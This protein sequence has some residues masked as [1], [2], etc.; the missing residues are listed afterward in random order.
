P[1]P[2]QSYPLE[3]IR[4]TLTWHLIQSNRPLMG[5]ID[6]LACQFEGPIETVDPTCTDWLG[7]PMRQGHI[8]TGAL[9]VQS[10]DEHNRYTEQDRELLAYVAQHLQTA[11]DRRRAKDQL[12]NRV[13]ERTLALREAN[14]VLQQQVLERQRGER[15]QAA[16]FRIAELT[17]TSDSPENFYSAIHQVI[18]ALLYARNFYIALLDEANDRLTFPYSVDEIDPEREPRT[19]GKG[20]TEYVLHRGHALLVKRKDIERLAENGDIT[21]RGNIAESWLG[22]PLTWNDQVMGVLAVQSHSPEHSY[23]PADQELLTFIS[24]HVVN[25][26]QR[27][28]DNESLKLAYTDMERRVVE[29]TRAL[30]LANRDLRMQVAERERAERRLKYETMHD[31]LTGLPNRALLL[32]RLDVAMKRY[33]DDP[34][35]LFA[36]LFIDLDRF[37]VINDS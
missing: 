7:V 34:S 9:V 20:L 5:R 4:H 36:V 14:R 10:H 1:D 13:A 37:K 3:S 31:P 27:I 30:A 21:V 2:T 24:Y 16:L 25:A 32:R 17:N 6:E 8:V 18:G 12:E 28:Q 15:L 29:R 26:L 33:R 23:G 35:Q 19:R 11:L 22:V